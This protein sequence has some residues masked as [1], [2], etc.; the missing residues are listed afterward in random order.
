MNLVSSGCPAPN[1]LVYPDSDSNRRT[2][3]KEK[4]NQRKATVA[5]NLVKKRKSK[6]RAVAKK[7][8]SFTAARTLEA[9]PP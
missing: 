6:E 5:K 2:P 4:K 3:G 8:F 1:R 7:P 9:K